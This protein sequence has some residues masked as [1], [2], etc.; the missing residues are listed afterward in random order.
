MLW[1]FLPPVAPLQILQ[2]RVKKKSTVSNLKKVPTRVSVQHNYRKLTPFEFQY[3]TV[4][5]SS[6]E[7][8]YNT[9]IES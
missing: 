6:L 3:N 2:R 1:Q 9:I 4:I 7:F 5:Y 8:Q